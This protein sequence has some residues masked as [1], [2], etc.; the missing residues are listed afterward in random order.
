MEV[1]SKYHQNFFFVGELAHAGLPSYKHA[2]NSVCYRQESHLRFVSHAAC[3]APLWIL[4]KRTDVVSVRKGT[5]K[6][7][8]VSHSCYKPY[9]NSSLMR[10]P[11]LQQGRKVTREDHQLSSQGSSRLRPKATSSQRET[12]R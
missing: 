4:I 12:T 10:C 7:I 11:L 6:G 3:E 1:C 8:A 2:D 9:A 5:M